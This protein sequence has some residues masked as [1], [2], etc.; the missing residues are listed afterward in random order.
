MEVIDVEVVNVESNTLTA[1]ET[2]FR[3]FNGPPKMISLQ[4]IEIKPKRKIVYTLS[5]KDEEFLKK[6]LESVL[7]TAN[8]LRDQA[9]WW[10]QPE[11]WT[12]RIIHISQ[13]Q[14]RKRKRYR[15]KSHKNALY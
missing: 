15:K 9:H 10:V 6:R 14:K 2:P 12:K 4:P 13:D 5:K 11:K 1:Q 7:V 3:L 8:D